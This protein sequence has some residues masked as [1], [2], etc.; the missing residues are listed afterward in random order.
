MP[1]GAQTY[2]RFIEGNTCEGKGTVG[3]R[4]DGR[5]TP[6][7]KAGPSLVKG[8]ATLGGG[9]RVLPTSVLALPGPAA[10]PQVVVAEAPGERAIPLQG[11]P[12][13]SAPGDCR[14]FP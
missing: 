6:D 3:A 14:H 2:R 13:S 10:D 8:K 5:E 4:G 1:R 7:P 12:P 9:G 11:F